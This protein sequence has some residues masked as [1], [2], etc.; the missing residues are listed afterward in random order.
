MQISGG[1]MLTVEYAGAAP[2]LVAGVS[3]IN[4]K[5]PDV[6]PDVAGY[7]RGVIPLTV[8]TPGVSYYPGYVTI[9]V[10]VN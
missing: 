2:G 10:D 7:P 8:I 4:V 9:A 6:I 1:P 3:Q 5:L